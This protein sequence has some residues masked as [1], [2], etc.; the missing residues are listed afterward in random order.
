MRAADGRA[1][2]DRKQDPPRRS[3]GQELYDLP[4]E[5]LSQGAD[6]VRL[7]ARSARK[8]EADHAY[9]L[10]GDVFSK[11]QIESL[12]RNQDGRSRAGK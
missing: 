8:P 7:A 6:R 12:Y 9:L 2:R 5:E 4:P 1:R 11:D 3:D 10:K